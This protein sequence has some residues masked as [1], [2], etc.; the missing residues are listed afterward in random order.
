M[1][2]LRGAAL[3]LVAAAAATGQTTDEAAMLAQAIAAHEQN[4][5]EHADPTAYHESDPDLVMAMMAGATAGETAETSE[6][7]A[8]TWAEGV[9]HTELGGVDYGDTV[10]EN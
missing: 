7:A 8:P 1:R 10:G 2:S 3:A 6:T 9:P 5:H 4:A